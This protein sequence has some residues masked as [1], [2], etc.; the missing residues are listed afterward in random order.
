MK[1]LR[2][3]LKIA[4]LPLIIFIAVVR[5]IF[6]ALTNLSCYVIGP[7]M[8][9]ILGCGIYTVV[10]QLW[11]QTFLLVLMEGACLLLL[12]GASFVLVTLE[13]WQEGLGDFLHS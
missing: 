7:L 9:L 10:K 5:F 12:F 1:I 13:N 2:I 11:S 3:L 8:L 4:A 6:N